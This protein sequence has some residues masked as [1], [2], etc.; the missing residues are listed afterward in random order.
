MAISSISKQYKQYSPDSYYHIYSRGVNKA[1]IFTC[2]KDYAIFFGLLKRYLSKQPAT[3]NK[4]RTYP[5]YYGQLELLAYALMPNHFHLLVYQ[6]EQRTIEEFMRSLLTS[7]SKYFNREYKRVGPVFQSRYL[8][9]L[10]VNEA[11]LYHISRYIHL[12]P[13][14]WR[15]TPTTSLDFYTGKRQADW[16]K[17]K[18]ILDLFKNT[19]TYIKFLEEYIDD[20]E[21]PLD[22]K[23]D[24]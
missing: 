20:E 2:D 14:N 11:Q 19:E 24:N 8:A 4:S 5:H 6:A 21:D 16:I 1:P 7:Y 17:P 12:N 22:I 10:I 13:I 9:K 18:R 15:G 3:N 23:I